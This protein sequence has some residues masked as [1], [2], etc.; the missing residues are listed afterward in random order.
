M[1]FLLYDDRF[2]S[3]VLELHFIFNFY[4]SDNIPLLHNPIHN[5]KYFTN[6]QCDLAH[7]DYFHDRKKMIENVIVY[8]RYF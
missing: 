3:K 6:L 8:Q 1:F 2:R 5:H 7:L 4:K